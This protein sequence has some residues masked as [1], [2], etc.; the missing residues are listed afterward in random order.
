MNPPTGVVTFLFT[1]IEGSTRRWETDAAAMRIALDA[2]DEALRKAIEGHGGWM[3]KH[4]GDGVI[5]AFASPP[6]AIDAAVAAQRA[7]ELPVRMGIATGEAERRGDDY[8]GVVLNRAARVMGAGHGGQILIADSTAELITGVDLIDLGPRRLRDVSRPV[9]IFQ[10][11]ADGLGVKFP[12]LKVLNVTPGNLRRPVTS[13]IGRESDVADVVAL[14]RGCRL[15]TLTGMGGVGKTR[16][17]IEVAE[18]LTNEFTDGVWFFELAAVTDPAAVP[19]AVA[20]VLGIAQQPG[21]SL[22]DSVALALEGRVRLL[23][24]DNC[25]HVLDA[26]A[27]LIEAILARSKTAK[28]V[29]TSRERLMVEG[30]QLWQVHSLDFGA[31]P[32]SAAVRLFVE[33]ASAVAPRMSLAQA[34]DAAAV[35]EICRRLDG[36]PLA[37]ELAASRMSSMT[38]SEICDRLDQRFRLLVGSR[39]A[40]ERHQTLRHA[41][42]WSYDQLDD[43]ERAMLARISAFAG[44]FDLEGACAVSESDEY[45]TLDLLD[46]LVRKS[47]VVVGRSDG[48]T[49]Y[50]LLETI[51]EFGTEMLTASGEA[52]AVRIA[53]AHHFAGLETK[54][55]A[56]WDS[57]Q[58][59]EA[60]VWFATELPN[61]RT[62]FRWSADNGDLDAAVAIVTG[63]FFLGYGIDNYEPV[64]WA[65]ELLEPARAVNHPRLA[66][67]YAMA[68]QCWLPGRIDD[69]LR[70]GDAA[71][72][73]IGSVG[74]ELPFG[75]EGLLSTPYANSGQLE[76][77]ID[78]CRTNLRR[79]R[80]THALTR[81]FLIFTLMVAGCEDEAMAV[82]DGLIEDAD[83]SRNP[84][85]LTFALM[86][87]GFAFRRTDPRRSREALQRGLEAA[88][89]TANRSNES[90]LAI[91]LAT[92]EATSV[93]PR[94]AFDCVTLAI[95]NLHDSGNITTVCSP[96]AILST[97]L[98]RLGHHEPAATI[99]GFAINP[100][101]AAAVPELTLSI[102]H[103][104]EALGDSAYEAL[105]HAGQA[106][107][108]AEM[109]AY[110]YDQIDEAR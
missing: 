47:L 50:S 63:T 91:C 84:Y 98:D 88:H 9:G 68:S 30:E 90:Q 109:V 34:H 24:F 93:D 87:Y 57:P 49:R 19:D 36:I 61:L 32:E 60:Y 62:G 45:T 53:H 14:L 41:V 74:D 10:L 44:G 92:V 83:T 52:T 20:S 16:L 77:A 78:W 100:F 73:L 1:D 4:T 64:A 66:Y 5:A 18:H 17:S 48:R 12:P 40:P 72:L 39:R 8:F 59:R 54:I 26:A 13:F 96:L 42:Q 81:S 110:A 29:A 86:V 51:R 75:A 99:A 21:M 108:N 89:E 101:T 71:R 46:A 22:V 67:L 7:L 6:S 11:R 107:S 43:A 97:V 65:E 104:R 28:I 58:Q 103:L 23:V 27:G 102:V 82:A 76:L 105:A 106:M 56:L 95:R 69:A 38:P 37:I 94:A 70:Y 15:V 3:F 85:T 80:D 25:E 31:G 2:H 55:L 79:G 33:R 35:V